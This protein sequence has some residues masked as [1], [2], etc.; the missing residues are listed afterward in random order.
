MINIFLALS[1]L[2]CPAELQVTDTST[3]THVSQPQQTPEPPPELGVIEKD[4][5]DQK[6]LGSS[7]CNIVLVD[8]NGEYWNLYDHKGK[9]IILDFSTAWCYPCQIA[10]NHTQPIQDQYASDVV[11]VTLLI[12][13]ESGATTTSADVQA[14]VEGHNITTAPVLQASREYVMDPAGITGY[15]VGGYPTYVYLDK[16]LK[17]ADA[18]VG[19]SEEYMKIILDGMLQ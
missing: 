18:H 10:G 5:C 12:E 8:Q 4:N 17:I 14:W 16:D 7:V 3:S 11:F 15:L 6:A 13:G 1:L 19:F 9:I 2:G